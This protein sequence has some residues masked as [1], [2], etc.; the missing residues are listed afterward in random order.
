MVAK[1]GGRLVPVPTGPALLPHTPQGS[2]AASGL[3]EGCLLKVESQ[4][5]PSMQIA[6]RRALEQSFSAS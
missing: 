6:H 2:V 3:P 4:T 1:E 5:L